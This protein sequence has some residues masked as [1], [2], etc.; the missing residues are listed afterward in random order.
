MNWATENLPRP[1]GTSLALV[2]DRNLHCNYEL[3]VGSR[4]DFVPT[5]VRVEWLDDAKLSFLILV[6]YWESCSLVV[7]FQFPSVGSLS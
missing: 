6:A 5:K 2:A 3:S 7:D 4:C 1:F